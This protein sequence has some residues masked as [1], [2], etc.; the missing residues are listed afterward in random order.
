MIDDTVSTPEYWNTMCE[1]QMIRI[2]FYKGNSDD[3]DFSE[4][5]DEN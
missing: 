5:S 4:V 2:N 3:E 1:E